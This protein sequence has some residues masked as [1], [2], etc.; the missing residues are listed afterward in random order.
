MN[1]KLFASAIFALGAIVSSTA[2]LAA[3]TLSNSGTGHAVQGGNAVAAPGGDSVRANDLTI[4]TDAD[5]EI[6][7]EDTI[8]VRLPAGLNF[9][10]TVTFTVTPKTTGTGLS[11]VDAFDGATLDEPAIAFTDTNGDGGMDR[12]S[13]TA[14][15]ASAGSDTV[16][17]SMNVAAGADV[18]KG[19][20][21]ATVA[22][23]GGVGA[24]Q[25]L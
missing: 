12:A 11:L 1:K 10:G 22:V 3:I 17:I 23:G 13:V 4:T 20:K 21:K 14:Y 16:T 18:V 2:A 7:A 5:D 6:A 24:A 19:V 15:A 25:A 9:D 8:V